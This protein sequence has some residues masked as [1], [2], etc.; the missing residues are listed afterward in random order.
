MTTDEI[1]HN[2]QTSET[3]V[4]EEVKRIQYLYQLQ[5]VI[6]SNLKR[7]ETIKTESVA[8]HV[9]G[10]CVLAQYFS[11]VEDLPRALDMQKVFSM[12][13]WHDIDEIETGDIVGFLKTEADKRGESDA[14]ATAIAS[15]SAI[16][17]TSIETTVAEYKKKESLEAR[18]VKA[19]D[20]LDPIFYFLNENGYNVFQTS[21]ATREQHCRIK[22][23]YLKDFP[24]MMRFHNVTLE[25]FEERGFFRKE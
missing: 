17:A 5:R 1:R 7:I 24:Y 12:I 11:I 3:F 25:L 9:Y 15:T 21:P 8:E 22:E 10:M 20:K 14:I 6:R 16:L 4:L 23:P 18:F 19:I 13:T 2:I